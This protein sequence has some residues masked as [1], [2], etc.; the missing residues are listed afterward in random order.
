MP[1]IRKIE[2]EQL[3]DKIDE[4]SRIVDHDGQLNYVFTRLC[5]NWL[6]K[7]GKKYTRINQLIGVLECAKLEFYRMIAAPYENIKIKENGGVG[8][9]L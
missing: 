4:I 5:H 3:D 2:R 9:D 7:V 6:R 1:Y 8:E